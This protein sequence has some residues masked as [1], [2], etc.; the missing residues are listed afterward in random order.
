MSKVIFF[1]HLLLTKKVFLCY[2]IYFYLYL[3]M[4]FYFYFF[5]VVAFNVIK[6]Y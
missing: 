5:I 4:Y 3:Y 1:L 6:N 2:Y